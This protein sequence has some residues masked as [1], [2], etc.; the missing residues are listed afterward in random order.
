MITQSQYNRITNKEW[1]GKRVR[2]LVRVSNRLGEIPSG[3]LATVV[4]KSRGLEIRTDPCETCGIVFF[5]SK[6]QPRDLALV[7]KREEVV[8]DKG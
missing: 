2:T 8:N 7:K 4:H 5:V 3:K 6:V 1:K